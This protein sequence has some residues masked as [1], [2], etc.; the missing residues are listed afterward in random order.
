[1]PLNIYYYNEGLY[2]K[3]IIKILNFYYCDFEP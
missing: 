3:V 1:M 2:A